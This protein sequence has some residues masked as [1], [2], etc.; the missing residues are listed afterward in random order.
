MDRRTQCLRLA[1]YR[2]A[3]ERQN[4][5]SGLAILQLGRIEIAMMQDAGSHQARH[6]RRFGIEMDEQYVLSTK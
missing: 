1:V 2:F 3:T 5:N 6:G 4:G